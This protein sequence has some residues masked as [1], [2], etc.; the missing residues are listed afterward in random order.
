MQQR[1]QL[2]H[3]VVL[4]MQE[5]ERPLELIDHQ[6]KIK[7][8]CLK[9]DCIENNFIV[10]LFYRSSNFKRQNTIDS[11]TIKENTARIAAQNQRPASATQKPVS[12]ADNSKSC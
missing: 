10:L 7:K 5:L 8:N 3:Q 12:S 9:C 6:C 2:S 1:Q 4:I 11:A